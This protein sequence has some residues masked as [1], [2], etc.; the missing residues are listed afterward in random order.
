M[1]TTL[2]QVAPAGR[3]RGCHLIGRDLPASGATSALLTAVTPSSLAVGDPLVAGPT[4][5]SQS[6]MSSASLATPNTPH[7]TNVG[8]KS[9]C[10]WLPLATD[11][12]VILQAGTSALGTIPALHTGMAPSA[13]AAGNPLA[14]GPA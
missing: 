5:Q 8:Y 4:V 13:L 6:A 2:K 7:M 14:M 11:A 10:E 9:K 3:R 1:G 12:G